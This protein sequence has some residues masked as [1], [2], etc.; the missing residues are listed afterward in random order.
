MG[1]AFSLIIKGCTNPLLLINKA[2]ERERGKMDTQPVP[3]L[4]NWYYQ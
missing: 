3:P 1:K 2:L 4:R